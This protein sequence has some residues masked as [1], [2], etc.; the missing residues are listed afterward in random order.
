MSSPSLTLS[1]AASAALRQSFLG[2]RAP[3]AV[4]ALLQGAHEM[5][6]EAGDVVH[7][8]GTPQGP[9][10]GV[11]VR[12]VVR[13]YTTSS[14]GRQVTVRYVSASEIF[15]L[16]EMLAPAVMGDRLRVSMQAVMPSSVLRLL[17][18]R[19]IATIDRSPLLGRAVYE[20]LARSLIAAYELLSENVFQPVLQRI[21]RHLLELAEREDGALVVHASQQEIADAIG[22]VREVVS[23]SLVRLRDEGHIARVHEGYLLID[24]AAL[25]RIAIAHS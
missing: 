19:F 8:V 3:D 25:H 20:E 2:V 4:A 11:I 5:H 9:M 12:G 18:S 24:P 23:R 10:V 1:D 21:A 17:P 13:I 7:R 6:F 22:S 16:P 14:G 15:G